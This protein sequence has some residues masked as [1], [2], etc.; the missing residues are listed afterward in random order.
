MHTPKDTIQSR[1]VAMLL[2]P[3]FNAAQAAA[4]REALEAAGAH[5]EVISTAL[6]VVKAADG[7]PMAVDKTSQVAASVLYDAVYVPGG[8]VHVIALAELDEV[9]RFLAEA[10][11]HGKPIGFSGEAVDL[12]AVLPGRNRQ[13]AALPGVVTAPGGDMAGFV[14]EFKAAMAQHR[15]PEREGARG[16]SGTPR[17]AVNGV[18]R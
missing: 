3:G 1:R 2:A 13:A 8:A 6:G 4:V 12:M 18:K 17:S 15:F 5:A 14:T 10:F 16:G 11:R 7:T 9:G